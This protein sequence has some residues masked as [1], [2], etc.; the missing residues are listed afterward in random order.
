MFK[1]SRHWRE[2][3]ALGASV[4]I[5]SRTDVHYTEARTCKVEYAQR[6]ACRLATYRVL[7][8]KKLNELGKPLQKA[9][10]LPSTT[11]LSSLVDDWL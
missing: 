7:T 5:W 9:K 8:D 10:L 6:I 4:R 11:P 1:P 3:S 2:F